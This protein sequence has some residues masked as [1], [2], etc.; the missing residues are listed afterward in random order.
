M[1]DEI[2]LE[3]YQRQP[4]GQA[5]PQIVDKA[6]VDSLVAA[7]EKI[8]AWIM[9]GAQEQDII[10]YVVRGVAFKVVKKL[11]IEFNQ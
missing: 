8:L 10:C 11:D 7:K 4:E 1:A 3:R 9:A 2:H 6:T 5:Q